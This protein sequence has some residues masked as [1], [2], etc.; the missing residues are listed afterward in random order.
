MR[1]SHWEE[2]LLDPNNYLK[3]LIY[4][5]ALVYLI[6]PIKEKTDEQIQ[7]GAI[8]VLLAWINFMWFF[9][10][11]GLGIYIIMAKKVFVSLLKVS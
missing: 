5:S 10:I 2:Y 7:A 11:L 4:I 9:R 3:W 1:L 8:A 6:P